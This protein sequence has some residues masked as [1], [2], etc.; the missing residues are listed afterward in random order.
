M[1]YDARSREYIYDHGWTI[2]KEGIINLTAE[3]FKR[4]QYT[5]TMLFDPSIKTLMI[6]S[7][8]GSTLILEGKHF[9][10]VD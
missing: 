1:M 5:G 3:Q 10:I 9:K 4:H 2:D 7:I 6:P 8:H